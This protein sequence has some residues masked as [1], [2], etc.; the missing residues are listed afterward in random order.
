VLPPPVQQP[1]PPQIQQPDPSI[2]RRVVR[3]THPLPSATAPPNG[4]PRNVIFRPE[5][6]SERRLARITSPLPSSAATAAPPRGLPERISGRLGPINQQHIV[7]ITITITEPLPP[8]AATQAPPDGLP[9]N[10]PAQSD[11][12]WQPRSVRYRQDLPQ[13]AAVLP[14]SSASPPAP[15]GGYPVKLNKQ[16]ASNEPWRRLHQDN[17]FLY[18]PET[19]EHFRLLASRRLLANL[20]PGAV[21]FLPSRPAR[22]NT[23]ELG[24]LRLPRPHFHPKHLTDSFLAKPHPTPRNALAPYPLIEGYPK[25]DPPP[26]VIG[27]RRLPPS[28]GNRLPRTFPPSTLTKADILECREAAR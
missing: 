17:P 27:I 2:E 21:I 28:I 11:S 4:H 3:Y 26:E 23:D 20:P 25:R 24:V 19:T 22:G 9:E 12:A 10:L 8:L 18:Q 5:S 16:L 6:S 15:P 14:E 1:H 7:R 13:R